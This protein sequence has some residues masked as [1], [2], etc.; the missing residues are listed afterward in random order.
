MTILQAIV[1]GERLLQDHGIQEA[2]WNAEQVASIVLAMPRAKIY[3]DP[4]TE[5]SEIQLQSLEQAFLK[6]ANHYPLA[7]LEGKQDFLGHDFVVN[8]NVLIPRPETEEI[9][10]GALAVPLPDNPRVLDI[11]TG[12]GILAITLSRLIDRSTIFAMEISSDALRVFRFNSQRSIPVVQGDLFQAP[13]RT[14]T[15][16]LVVSNPPYVE[17]RELRD[18]P[19]ETLWEPRVALV[20]A[21]LERVYRSLLQQSSRILKPGGFLIFEIGYG[22]RDRIEALCAQHSQFRILDIRI[23]DAGIARTFV[24]IRI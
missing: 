17:E 7:Y 13:F 3:T 16:D 2:R 1:Q 18:L 14:A 19:P 10:R 22:Q 9:V 4:G 21:S 24:L 23:D 8:E 5:L 20:A 6:R 12:S 15:F 11:G